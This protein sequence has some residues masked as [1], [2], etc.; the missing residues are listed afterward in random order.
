VV[1]VVERSKL[2][3]WVRG[4]G[5]GGAVARELRERREVLFIFWYRG[6]RFWYLGLVWYCNFLF[7][8]IFLHYWRLFTANIVLSDFHINRCI[9]WRLLAINKF[10]L[11]FLKKSNALLRAIFIYWGFLAPNKLLRAK[12]SQYSSS[13]NWWILVVTERKKHLCCICT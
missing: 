9:F 6:K 2:F 5:G 4:C 3:R 12:S 13:I 10:Y 8:S 1:V 11:V 7:L